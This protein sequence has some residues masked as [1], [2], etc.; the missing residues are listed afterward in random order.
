MSFEKFEIGQP[1][2]SRREFVKR[3]GLTVAGFAAATQALSATSLQ[4]GK[5]RRRVPLNQDWFLKSVDV[6]ASDIVQLIRD[7]AEPDANWLPTAMPKQVQDV[8]LDCGRI[9]DPAIGKNAAACTWVFEKDWVYACRFATPT[10]SETVFLRLPGV[11]TRCDVY[12]N[13][14]HVGRCDNMF[15]R[16]VFEIGGALEVDQ[17]NVLLLVFHSPTKLLDQIRARIGEHSTVRPVKYLRKTCQDFQSYLGATPHFLKM[18]VFRDID[19]DI[20]GPAWFGDICLRPT[21]VGQAGRLQ[22][23]AETQ[24]EAESIRW[25]LKDPG[26]RL[27]NGEVAVSR[28]RLDFDVKVLEPE[29]WWPHT[30]GNPSLYEL[31]LDLIHDGQIVDTYSHPIGFRTIE[32]VLK[33]ADTGQERFGFRINGQ[34]IFLGGACWAPLDGKTHVWDQIRANRLLDMTQ[35]AHMNILRVWGAGNLPTEEFYLE[36]DRRGILVW[37]DFMTAMLI[38]FPMDDL[39]FRA[40]ITAELVDNIKRLR[41]HTSLMMW[42]GGNEHYRDIENF[43]DDIDKPM[44]RE[45]FEVLMPELVQSHDPARLFHRSSP[46]GVSQIPNDPLSGNWHDYTAAKFMPNS[47]VPLFVSEFC[48]VSSP[49]FSEMQKI[50]TPEELWPEGFV[51]RIDSPGEKAWPAMWEYRALGSAWE[52]KGP[53][54]QFMEPRSAEEL[55]RVLGIAHGEENLRHIGRYRRGMPNGQPDGNRRCGGVTVW[56]LNDAWPIVYMANVGYYLEPK[57]P[58]YYLKRVYEPVFIDFERTDDEINVWL[59]NDSPKQ[60]GG[61]LELKK[62]AFDGKELSSLSEDISLDPGKSK[63]FLC[64]TPLGHINRA[65]EFLAAQFNGQTRT[66]L[67]V[68][69][70][71]LQLPKARLSV[72]RTNKGFHVSSDKYARQ[73]CLGLP[74]TSGA[75]F[76]D[77]WFDLIPGEGKTITLLDQAQGQTLRIGAL[78]AEAVFVNL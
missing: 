24:G 78:N 9:P 42:C 44:G 35:D 45:L 60:V 3:T 8:L 65:Q 15:R 56:R 50:L 36:C 38:D 1:G 10:T 18:G 58:Y 40:N 46:W 16:H 61:T 59:V 70:R 72:E 2:L 20:P 71:Y 4:V 66:L 19:L 48:R 77:N 76:S 47:S 7:A 63:R 30:H 62:V 64:A 21:V 28:E 74:G 43:S 54:E 25:T 32:P 33:D 29:L 26:G 55:V 23:I 51:Y 11:D 37:Q 14:Q 22:I 12:L 73:V 75:W 53:V 41:N 31:A 52:K 67:L 57:I 13:N 68:G 69:E 27:L 5:G 34:M 39:E 6:A 17:D 49:P